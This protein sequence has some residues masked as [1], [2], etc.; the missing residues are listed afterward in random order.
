MPRIRFHILAVL[1]SLALSGCGANTR[2]VAHDL[3]HGD[4]I[5]AALEKYRAERGHYPD[6]LGE[7]EPNYIAHIKQPRYGEHRWDY[8]RY[9]EKGTFALFI[10]GAKPYHDGYG[11]KA[12]EAKWTRIE[13]SF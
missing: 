5:V 6:T 9:C 12:Q 13:N 2:S 10:W 3:K 8:I 7:L 11:Y 1:V 4:E